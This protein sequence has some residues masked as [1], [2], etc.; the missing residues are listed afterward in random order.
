MA[1]L[2]SVF[3]K[4]ESDE[5]PTRSEL[6]R[7][8]N[9]EESTSKTNVA[10]HPNGTNVNCRMACCAMSDVLVLITQ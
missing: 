4:L 8:R 6:L 9:S 3:A 7:S 1:E 10:K 2:R 5:E